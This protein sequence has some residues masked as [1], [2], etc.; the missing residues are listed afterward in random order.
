MVIIPAAASNERSNDV[1]SI[2]TAAVAE[3]LRRV[4]AVMT[5]GG[6]DAL[7]VGPSADLLHLS[8]YDARPSE[9]LTALVVRADGRDRMVVPTLERPLVE[10]LGLPDS[11]TIDAFSET[12]DPYALAAR[13]LDG[14]AEAP[15]IGVGD[16]LWA[17]FL[18]G[19]QAEVPDARWVPASSVT[20]ELRMRK[21]P[22]EVEALRRAAQAIDRVHARM[23]EWLRP[24]RSE[25]EVGEDVRAA[26]L[27]EGHAEVSFC[28]VAS[29]PNGASPHHHTSDRV[30][31][32]GD[33]VVVDIGGV[34]DG[35]GSDNT[36]MY[37][38]GEVAREII[39]A[40][41]VLERAQR[42]A[43]AHAAPGETAGAVDAAARDVLTD[44]GYGEYFVHRTGHGIGL[45]GHE[46]PYIVGG[47]DQLLEPGMTF[48]IEPGLYVPGRFGLRIEDI[49]VVT[50]D[51]CERLN[52]IDRAAVRIPGQRTPR[53]QGGRNELPAG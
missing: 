23:P 47:N 36:R 38:V 27:A 9:R 52:T 37:F 32:P 41:E 21:D 51:G 11:V 40:H 44:A 26:I 29:G 14:S 25:A 3:R 33:A 19:L 13:A 2:D 31:R 15:V 7:V 4:R 5:D 53:P 48:S 30:I 43:V 12:D 46:E 34:M 1:T 17:M 24:G 20:R 16:R 50:D 18:L 49:V 42:T 6:V 35:Y 45:E 8:G 10:G 28:I 22:A 39:D